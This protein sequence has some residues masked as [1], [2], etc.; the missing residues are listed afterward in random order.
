MAVAS[1]CQFIITHNVKDFKRA[2][3]LNVTAI[4]PAEFLTLLRST[5]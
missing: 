4:T 5:P 3:D 2:H 1:G